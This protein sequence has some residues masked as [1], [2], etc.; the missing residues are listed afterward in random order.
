[1]TDDNM[2]QTHLEM[3]WLPVTAPDGRTRMEAT[4]VEVGHAVAAHS[5]A[6]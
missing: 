1:M 2:T 3:R 5:H 4:W 6:A